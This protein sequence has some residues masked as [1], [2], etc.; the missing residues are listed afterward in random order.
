MT[1]YWGIYNSKTKGFISY[2]DYK[3]IH[4][5]LKSI[6]EAQISMLNHPDISIPEGMSIDNLEVRKFEDDPT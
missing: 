5:P 1:N 4:Y 2:E 6:A 3:V